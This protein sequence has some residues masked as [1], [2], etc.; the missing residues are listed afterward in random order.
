MN[1]IDFD[2]GHDIE[3]GLLEA[4]SEASGAGKQIDSDRPWH[5]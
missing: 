1:G 4:Q 3:T 5:L 2:C